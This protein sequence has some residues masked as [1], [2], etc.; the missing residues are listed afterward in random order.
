MC[1][2]YHLACNTLE[3]NSYHPEKKKSHAKVNAYLVG[4]GRM[5]AGRREQ[6]NQGEK[7]G[8]KLD[9]LSGS[10]GRSPGK[11]MG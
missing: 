5:A 11:G 8:P 1:V 6:A 3:A 10:D 4:G 2:V 7:T 9:P